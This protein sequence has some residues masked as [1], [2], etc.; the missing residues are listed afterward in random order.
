MERQFVVFV[1]DNEYYGVDIAL[2]ERIIEVRTIA[3]VPYA[4]KFIQGVTNL[5]GAVLPVVDLRKRFE[6]AAKPPDR[7]TR[8]IVVTAGKTRVGMIVDAVAEVRTI[9]DADIESPPSIVMTVKSKFIAGIA[10]VRD[11]QETGTQQVTSDH[12]IIILNLPNVLSTRE[13]TDLV[14]FEEKVTEMSRP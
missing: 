5:D 9:E 12:L 7:D 3:R 10:K 11:D 2:V 6:F 13:K 14:T 1:L 4:P 8:I